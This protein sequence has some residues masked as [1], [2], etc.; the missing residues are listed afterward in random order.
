MRKINKK[1][2]EENKTKLKK[3]KITKSGFFRRQAKEGG[4]T[5]S[6]TSRHQ[7]RFPLF[8]NCYICIRK[9]DVNRFVHCT[10]S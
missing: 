10:D 2:T 3:K 7:V 6:S 8:Y 5:S 1:T 4:S 9:R